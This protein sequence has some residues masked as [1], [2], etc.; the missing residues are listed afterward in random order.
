MNINDIKKMNIKR[1][2]YSAAI[3]VCL[4]VATSCTNGLDIVPDNVATIDHAFANTV[5]AEKYFLILEMLH[6]V[7]T[8]RNA[9][10]YCCSGYY[11]AEARM[12][13]G[14]YC[15]LTSDLER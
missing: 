3:S 14:L 1:K 9:R 13:T 10:C 12:H 5:E 6:C 11:L 8:R 15:P 2:L 4:L 7:T